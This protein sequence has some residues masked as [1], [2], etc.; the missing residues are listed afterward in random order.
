[1]I[2]QNFVDIQSKYKRQ[3]IGQI[4]SVYSHWRFTVLEKILHVSEV[5]K[6]IAFCDHVMQR[7]VSL[8][9]EYKTNFPNIYKERVAEYFKL[10][11]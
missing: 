1:M 10:P 7:Q 2:E 8:Y 3:I 9:E 5:P 11:K 4:S 6:I